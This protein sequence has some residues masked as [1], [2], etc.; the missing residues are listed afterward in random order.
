MKKKVCQ[1]CSRV[2]RPPP[3]P[4]DVHHS[5]FGRISVT[6]QAVDSAAQRNYFAFQFRIW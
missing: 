1:M 4:G 5:S 6:V 3:E 2:G